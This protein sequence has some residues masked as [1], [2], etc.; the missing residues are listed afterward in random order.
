[1]IYSYLYRPIMEHLYDGKF[2][3]SLFSLE[4]NADMIMAK[5]LSTYIFENYGVRLS[6]KQLLSV[7][8]GFILNDEC[9]KIVQDCIPWMRQVESILTVYDKNLTANAMYMHLMTELEARGKFTETDKRKIYTPNDPDLIH[10]VITDHLGRIF[11]SQGNTLKQEMDLA[12]KYLY[13]LKNRCG[14]SPVV[15]QQLNRNMKSMD[16]RKEGLVCPETND[17]KDTNSS[18]EDA[19]IILAIFSPN[20]SKLSTHRGYDIKQLG[21]KF[22]SLCVLKSRYGE[23]DVEDAVYYD[24]QCNKWVE[25]MRPNEI[26]DYSMFDNPKWYQEQ[27]DK[28]SNKYNLSL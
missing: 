9:Y 25:L 5:L 3:A 27:L 10:V 8:R 22:R 16:R 21:D 18:V 26:T 17:L 14:I 13:N 7:K 12:S 4:M 2:R 20:K 15:L 1:M 19:E 23:A 24:G 6:I 28:P 11:P